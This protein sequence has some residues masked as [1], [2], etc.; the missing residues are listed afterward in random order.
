MQAHRLKREIIATVLANRVIDISGPVFLLR[1]R[2]Q[3]G[4]ENAAIAAAVE[5]ARVLLGAAEL[6]EQINALDNQV[7]ANHQMVLQHTL[8]EALSELS[9]G[10]LEA[11]TITSIDETI[12]RLSPVAES[13]SN[14][15]PD[16]LSG[17][18]ASRLN[19]SIKTLSKNSRRDP[20]AIKLASAALLSD[21]PELATIAAEFEAKPQA[22]FSAFQT[23]GD[24]LHLDRLRA[25]ALTAVQSMPYCDRLATRR[26]IRELQRQQCEA[27]R[28]ALS[29]GG[30][31]AW[32]SETASTRK[33][34]IIDIRT[35]TMNAPGFA[36]F[37]LA[38]DAVRA[39]MQSTNK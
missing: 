39:F 34:L 37:A 25:S 13:L 17:F 11:G 4:A 10:L 6:Q 1:L 9:Q 23:I 7:T 24:A 5:T 22:I 31:D 29:T 26:L 21:L 35:Y 8:T 2:E 18:E 12:A 20:L 36:Q 15:L 16:S 32:V 33:S 38:A 28:S 30:S 27:V 14:S 3:T 19:K